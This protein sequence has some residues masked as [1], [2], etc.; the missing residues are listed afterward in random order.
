MQVFHN[1]EKSLKSSIQITL[2][3]LALLFV[4]A[5]I[6][7]Q[8]YTADSDEITLVEQVCPPVTSLT[9]DPVKKIWTGPGNW[10]SLNPSFSRTLDRFV[11]AQWVG[12]G[13]GHIVC[14]YTNHTQVSFVVHL[15][16]NNLVS[17]P[18]GGLW[19]KDKGGHKD[20]FSSDTQQCSYSVINIIKPKNVHE[21]IDFYNKSTPHTR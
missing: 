17:S 12:V 6:L 10:H 21:E 3:L 9:Q 7:A 14:S 18:V 16:R 1:K 2:T 20:C 15:Q 13:V 19:S 4:S 5:E 8:A 11:G